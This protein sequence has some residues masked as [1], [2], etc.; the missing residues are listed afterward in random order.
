MTVWSQRSSQAQATCS[1]RRWTATYPHPD[2]RSQSARDRTVVARY[3]WYLLW[4]SR[5]GIRAATTLV[6]L[7]T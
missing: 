1:T 7:D 4:L 5:H 6:D 2:E 3:H